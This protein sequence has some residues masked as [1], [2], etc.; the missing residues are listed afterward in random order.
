MLILDNIEVKTMKYIVIHTK[1]LKTV[2]QSDSM[3]EIQAFLAAKKDKK[4]YRVL[5]G[6]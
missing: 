6:S 2:L 1:T 4:L 3:R 5:F